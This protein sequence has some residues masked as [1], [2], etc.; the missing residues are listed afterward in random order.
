MI[1]SVSG[2]RI[3]FALDI[4]GYLLLLGNAAG[5]R[6]DG[7]GDDVEGKAGRLRVLLLLVRVLQV[8]LVVRIL[9]LR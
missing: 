2:R 6:H 5:E 9:V 8:V 3:V 1:D 4:L 7:L